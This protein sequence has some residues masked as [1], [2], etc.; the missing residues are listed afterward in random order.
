MKER[1]RGGLFQPRSN[2]VFTYVI[3]GQEKLNETITK[4]CRIS[5]N[6]EEKYL[7][8]LYPFPY[9]FQL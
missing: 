4:L 1:E 7:E 3:E 2:R 8:Y 6:L 9:F 5:A